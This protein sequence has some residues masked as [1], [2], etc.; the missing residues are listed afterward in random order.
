MA[1]LYFRYGT[2]NSGKSTALL[3]AAYNYEE[4]GM[5]VLIIKSAVDTKGGAAIVSRLGTTRNADILLRHDEPI[6]AQ[7][8]ELAA[9][10]RLHCVLVDE[11]QFLAPEQVEELFWFA[12]EADVPVMAY[13]LR[14]DFST[15]AFSGSP[16][17]LELAH[18]LQELKTICRC[19]KKAVLNGRKID[20]KFVT[21]GGQVAID[22]APNIEYEA[23]CA[24]DY[25]RLVRR[26]A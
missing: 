15:K 3:Q 23:L 6:R 19:G 13:G 24:A 17:L 5:R 21:E 11:A 7:L 12:V 4:R 25:Q 2:M 1:K 26:Q 10:H 20:G 22:D 18:E 8:D 14:T 9:R 16:R